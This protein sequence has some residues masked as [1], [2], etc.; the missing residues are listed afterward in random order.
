MFALD[1]RANP[2]FDENQMMDKFLK[3]IGPNGSS[4]DATHMAW[5]DIRNDLELQTYTYEQK[6]WLIFSRLADRRNP[7]ELRRAG[8]T[9]RMKH[10]RKRT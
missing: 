1:E 8:V 5:T 9:L 2:Y 3:L 10:D 6:F 4:I 7:P